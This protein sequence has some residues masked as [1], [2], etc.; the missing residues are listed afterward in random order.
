MWGRE[1][2]LGLLGGND[3]GEVGWESW[4]GSGLNED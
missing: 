3:E 1:G 4:D 2:E